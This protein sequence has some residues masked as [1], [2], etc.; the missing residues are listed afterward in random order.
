MKQPLINPLLITIYIFEIQGKY[1]RR[2]LQKS[3]DFS[4]IMNSARHPD[5]IDHTLW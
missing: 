5:T 2:R 3:N 4:D 1:E